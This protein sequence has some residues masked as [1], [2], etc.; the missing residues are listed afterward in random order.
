MVSKENRE[1]IISAFEKLKSRNIMNV[2]DELNDDFR[3]KFEHTVLASFGIDKYFND[4]KSSLLSMF[5]TRM[6]VKE[7]I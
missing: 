7:E 6:T 3:L 1:K 4:I 5:E 2:T